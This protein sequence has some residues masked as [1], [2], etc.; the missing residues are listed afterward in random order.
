MKRIDALIRQAEALAPEEDGVYLL[1][2]VTIF[3]HPDL[4]EVA[5]SPED[6]KEAEKV[7][8]LDKDHVIVKC[9]L[10]GKGSGALKPAVPVIIR[11]SQT[12][13]FLKIVRFVFPPR[14]YQ[15]AVIWLPVKPHQRIITEKEIS[16]DVIMDSI[17]VIEEGGKG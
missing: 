12:D 10:Y 6:L 8:G 14:D 13:D 1:S 4:K 11:R 15:K 3:F 16:L 17:K 7:T 9:E 2:N 5:R